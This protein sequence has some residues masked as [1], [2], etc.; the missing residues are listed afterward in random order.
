MTPFCKR[1]QSQ[2]IGIR[3][4][5]LTEIE[6]FIQL[7]YFFFHSIENLFSFRFISMPLPKSKIKASKMAIPRGYHD[8][9]NVHFHPVTAHTYSPGSEIPI[10][11][12]HE[13]YRTTLVIPASKLFVKGV[14]IAPKCQKR[15]L[16][17]TSPSFS[18][19]FHEYSSI[20]TFRTVL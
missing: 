16:P 13:R 5:W 7:S 18:I 11:G 1:V 4:F 14:K 20:Y 9:K 12:G 17:I 3:T 15:G 6:L 8:P 10:M 19:L 2:K